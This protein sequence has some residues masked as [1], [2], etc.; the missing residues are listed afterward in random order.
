MI[1][2]RQH[3]EA[4]IDQIGKDDVG[5]KRDEGAG[6]SKSESAEKDPR[7]DRHAAVF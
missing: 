6:H 2:P 3:A 1:L 7:I 5:E 4:L